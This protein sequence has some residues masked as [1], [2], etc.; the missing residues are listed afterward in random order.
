[1]KMKALHPLSFK[2][3]TNQTSSKPGIKL[4]NMGDMTAPENGTTTLA[5][6]G[7]FQ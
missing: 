6:S 4:V 7:I 5:P 3:I 2:T 1:M